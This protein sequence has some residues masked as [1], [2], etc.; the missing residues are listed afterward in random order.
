MNEQSLTQLVGEIASGN[1]HAWPGLIRR[2]AP[3][4][5]SVVRKYRVDDELRNDAVGEVWRILFE[6]LDTVEDP[7][8]LCGWISAVASNQMI[9]MLRRSERQREIVV[10]NRVIEVEAPVDDHD[11]LIEAEVNELLSCAVSKLSPREQT[12]IRCRALTDKPLSLKSMEQRYGI[13]AG[14]I[15]PTLGRGLSKLRRDP[16]LVRF[17]EDNWKKTSPTAERSLRAL[18]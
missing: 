12:V 10:I 1:D 7:E 15:G 8:R 16:Q 9:S 5:Y 4:V 2:L 3:T 11:R 13:P 17:F 18:S 14:S 6:R